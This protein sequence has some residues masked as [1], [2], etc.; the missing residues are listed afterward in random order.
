[1]IVYIFYIIIAIIIT[2][3][4]L[5][6]NKSIAII[7]PLIL[8]YLIG[9]MLND[10][11]SILFGLPHEIITFYTFILLFTKAIVFKQ[12]K[13]LTI[14]WGDRIFFLFYIG[15]Y[16]I[17]WLVNIFDYVNDSNILIIR[18]LLPLKIWLIYRIFLFVY[19]DK[20]KK[21]GFYQ[22]N[23]INQTLNAYTIGM[24]FSGI[25]GTLRLVNIPVISGYIAETWPFVSTLNGNFTRMQGTVGGIN[26]GGILTAI[27]LI[28]A[29]HLYFSEKKFIY[30]SYVPILFL[31]LLLSASVSSTSIFLI[32]LVYLSV[33]TKIFT[34]K[35]L[36]LITIIASIL[37][38]VFLINSELN[39]TLQSTIENRMDD[40]FSSDT[41]FS[42]EEMLPSS[43]RSRMVLWTKYV[44]Y[45][46]EK[47]LMGYGYRVTKKPIFGSYA[48]ASIGESYFVDL[49]LYGGL[50]G[51]IAYLSSYY[52]IY[53]KAT[54]VI[55]KRNDA[56]LLSSILI[57]I[58][59]SQITNITLMYGG[60]TELFGIII[61]FTYMLSQFDKKHLQILT[62][63]ETPNYYTSK[64]R[65]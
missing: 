11:Y 44:D 15:V 40:Q 56:S 63:Y 1:M 61:F 45:F 9:G 18:Q 33:K 49:L 6:S 50:F 26:G 42:G 35:K 32:M 36:F 8:S 21:K 23:I 37:F 55:L 43:F 12:T 29:L 28:F 65:S 54:S 52:L 47:P 14:T 64:K 38:S 19:I 5:I 7:K 13:Q 39:K 48:R 3:S 4:V 41:E 60:L 17:P 30:I 46:I 2:Q 22:G 20:I 53:S 25:V 59:L 58:F 34:L 57:G 31:F 16:I 24:I 10:D 27:A 51:L 62:N